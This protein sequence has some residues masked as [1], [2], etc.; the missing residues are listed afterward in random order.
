MKFGSITFNAPT[1]INIE[2]SSQIHL[3]LSLADTVEKLKKYIVEEGEKIGSNIKVSDVMDAH[4]SGSM[5]RIEKITPE[6]QAVSKRQK[7]EWKWEIHP[8]K[9]G[10]HKLHLTLTAILKIDGENT[11]RAI[12]SFEK[13][14]EINVT[15][16]QK[17]VLFFKSNWQWLWTVIL[18]P[19]VGWLWKRRK[20]NSQVT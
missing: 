11:S 16:P 5:F 2:D 15:T 10:K 9:E 14:I 8:T 12:K 13:V 7:T 19:V 17:I 1:N 3:V 20:S 4:L 6:R 18:V